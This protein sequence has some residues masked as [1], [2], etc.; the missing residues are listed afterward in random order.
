MTVYG[1]HLGPVLLAV[2]LL[3]NLVGLAYLVVRINRL[4]RDQ[5]RIVG[6][7]IANGWAVEKRKHDGDAVPDAGTP[8][9]RT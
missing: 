2:M 4:E 6:L 5:R 8:R 1:A 7:M 9:R 3:F